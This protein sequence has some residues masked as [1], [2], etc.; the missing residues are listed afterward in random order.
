MN[1]ELDIV[2][3]Q[4]RI[5]LPY[6][7]PGFWH[8]ARTA[9]L[10]IADAEEAQGHP[11]SAT[12]AGYHRGVGDTYQ[13]IAAVLTEGRTIEDLPEYASWRARTTEIVT[14]TA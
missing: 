14:K 13:V 10:Q 12:V 4:P 6:T 7:V 11:H 2:K 9:R 1:D 3:E 5:R 8:G